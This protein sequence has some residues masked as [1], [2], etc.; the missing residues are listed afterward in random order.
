MINSSSTTT[1]LSTTTPFTNNTT[2]NSKKKLPPSHY[3]STSGNP[4]VHTSLLPGVRQRE[5]TEWYHVPLVMGSLSENAVNSGLVNLI[6]LSHATRLAQDA[7]SVGWAG[8]R[9][10]KMRAP[11]LYDS[12]GEQHNHGQSFG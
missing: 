4:N 9:V 2:G 6:K 10:G 8:T 3:T 5:P 12:S 1:A 7:G 11:A